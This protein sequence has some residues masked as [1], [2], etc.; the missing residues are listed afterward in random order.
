MK[1]LLVILLFT[2]SIS[3]SQDESVIYKTD[4][5][6]FYGYDFSHAS[7]TTKHP[8]NDHVFNWIVSISEQI[9]PSQFEKKMCMSVLHNFSYTNNVN[10]EFIENQIVGGLT[11][12]INSKDNTSRYPLLFDNHNTTTDKEKVNDKGGRTVMIIPNKRLKEYISEYKLKKDHGIGL[13]SFVSEISKPKESTLLQFVFFDIKTRDIITSFNINVP[14]A[15]GVGM[16]NHWAAN[17]A[18]CV[19]KFL[20]TYNVNLY[21]DYRKDYKRKRKRMRK[22]K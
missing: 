5:I 16:E 11:D 6:Y 10:S 20:N 19:D 3:Y 2:S 18:S 13:V 12:Q 21:L 22:L 15:T 9:P 17:F 4:T 14:G 8:I 1:Y 7:V